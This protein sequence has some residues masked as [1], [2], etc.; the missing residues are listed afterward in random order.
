MARSRQSLARRRYLFEETRIGEQRIGEQ[1]DWRADGLLLF[2]IQAPEE[3]YV[4]QFS[5]DQ[6]RTS[7]LYLSGD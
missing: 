2:S 6:M 1:T 5:A 3:Y 4:Y 7:K